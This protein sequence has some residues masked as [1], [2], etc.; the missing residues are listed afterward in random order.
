MDEVVV[1]CSVLVYGL[2]FGF[3]AACVSAIPLLTFW[4]RY[5]IDGLYLEEMIEN[6]HPCITDAAPRIK[7]NSVFACVED[8]INFLYRLT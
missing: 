1:L 5:R 4:Y 8:S 7:S 2:V 6:P 3:G